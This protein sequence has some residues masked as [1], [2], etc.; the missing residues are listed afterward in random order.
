MKGDWFQ[1]FACVLNPLRPCQGVL[2][3]GVRT[4]EHSLEVCY[5]VY[6]VETLN[7]RNRLGD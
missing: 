3:M 6:L 5:P 4:S 1:P 2:E 7:C